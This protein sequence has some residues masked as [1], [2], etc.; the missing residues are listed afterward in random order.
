MG[1]LAQKVEHVH[2]KPKVVGSSSTEFCF[3]FSHFIFKLT[4]LGCMGLVVLD[5]NNHYVSE[6]AVTVY[7]HS[8]QI[9]PGH[10]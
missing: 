10:L 1:F 3:F 9:S 7:S 6:F 8:R 2:I 5:L 4:M